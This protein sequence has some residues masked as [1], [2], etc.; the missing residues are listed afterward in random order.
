MDQTNIS[1]ML[2][3]LKDERFRNLHYQASQGQIHYQDLVCTEMP[4]GLSVEQTWE[5][6]TALRKQLGSCGSVRETFHEEGSWYVE[7]DE[8]RA[9]LS[10][11]DAVCQSYSRLSRATAQRDATNLFLQPFTDDILAGMKRDA[12]FVEHETVRSLLLGERE[13][14]GYEERI[15]RNLIAILDDLASY[16]DYDFDDNLIADLLSKILSGVDEDVSKE[17][18]ASELGVR[19]GGGGGFI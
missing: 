2:G 1:G 11:I 18:A 3:I 15:A 13:P 8:I 16:I 10:D 4:Q 12:L 17:A 19:A 14:V 9:I 5:L 7:N 6:I